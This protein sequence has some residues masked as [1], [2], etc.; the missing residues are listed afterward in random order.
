M[1]IDIVANPQI[2]DKTDHPGTGVPHSQ[3]GAKPDHPVTTPLPNRAFEKLAS[4]KQIHVA[5]V[6]E[7]LQA[8][9]F[10]PDEIFQIKDAQEKLQGIV[11]RDTVRKA[12]NTTHLDT[13]T[14]EKRYYYPPVHDENENT[15][16]PRKRGRPS[17][18]GV[19][20]RFPTVDHLCE[21]L[22]VNSDGYA[23]S[24]TLD[25]CRKTSR[26][27]RAKHVRLIQRAEGKQLSTNFLAKRLGVQRRRI[28]AYNR[29]EGIHTQAVFVKIPITLNHIPGFGQAK[30]GR[31]DELKQAI[32]AFW[33]VQ[34]GAP[35]YLEDEDGKRYPARYQVA[36]KLLCER[37]RVYMIQQVASRYWLNKTDNNQEPIIQS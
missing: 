21:I 16:K 37:K 19:K 20:H 10:T 15:P 22:G 23:D 12:I 34:N 36:F 9:G 28:H 5:R 11:G 30:P 1:V 33:T 25:D 29:I 13:D 31:E 27:R 18:S 7:A 3:N 35:I 24:V 32:E 2:N 6:Y 4:L 26:Y 8:T 14:G 17:N